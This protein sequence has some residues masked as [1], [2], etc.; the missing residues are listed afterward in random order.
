MSIKKMVILLG[1]LLVFYIVLSCL[2]KKGG[3]S[4]EVN[5]TIKKDD[6][7]LEVKEALIYHEKNEQDHYSFEVRVKNHLFSFRIFEPLHKKSY[8]IQDISYYE[9]NDYTCIY[10]TFKTKEEFHSI[11]CLKDNIMYPYHTIKGK[12]VEVDNF[13][14]TLEYNDSAYIEDKT[15]FLKKGT[16]TIYRKNILPNHYLAVENYKGLSLINQKD[17]YKNIEL[18]TSDIYTKTMTIFDGSFY[19]SADYNQKYTFNELFKIDIKSGKKET[20]ISNTALNLDGYFMGVIDENAYFFDKSRKEQYSVSLENKQIRKNGNQ[21][22][23]IQIYENG[24]WKDVSSY[25][26]YQNKLTFHQEKIVDQKYQQFD[27]V[28]KIGTHKAG[29]YYFYQ[30]DGNVYHVYK[31]PIL[32]ETQYTYLFDTTNIEQVVY[33]NDFIYYIY[34]KDVRYYSDMTGSK[35]VLSNSE[36]AYNKSLKFGVFLS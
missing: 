18:F 29:S 11:L 16:L 4:H 10:P 13:V 8:I 14:S 6:V 30:K 26:A 31:A 32:N 33:Q 5:Y 35:T 21:D 19:L 22:T 12:S 28:D 23:G 15:D 7:S 2:L 3:A 34:D 25:V 9:G 1:F 20:L 27:R 17:V 24:A 36:F